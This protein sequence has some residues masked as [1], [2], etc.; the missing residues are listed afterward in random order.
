MCALVPLGWVVAVPL[1]HSSEMWMQYLYVCVGRGQTFKDR[2]TNAISNKMLFFPSS[3]LN[4][5]DRKYSYSCVGS[6]LRV[7]YLDLKTF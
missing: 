5:F 4:L 1:K 7:V 2:F 6:K 3:L